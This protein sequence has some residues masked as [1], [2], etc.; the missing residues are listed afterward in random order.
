[1]EIVHDQGTFK[2]IEGKNNQGLDNAALTARES[3]IP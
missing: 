3:L 2:T 1:M